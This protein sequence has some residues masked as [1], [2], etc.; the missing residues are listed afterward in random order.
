MLSSSLKF[1]HH[2]KIEWHLG[3]AS[4]GWNQASWRWYK[5]FYFTNW[6]LEFWWMWFLLHLDNLYVDLDKFV[7]KMIN[8]FFCPPSVLIFWYFSFHA[9]HLCWS[10]YGCTELI[11]LIDNIFFSL[12]RLYSE[13]QS[14]QMFLVWRILKTILSTSRTME[15]PYPWWFLII[16]DQMW[17]AVDTGN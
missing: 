14:S 7:I 17:S 1:S 5:V 4:M 3:R 16:S 13:L 8:I 15:D 12:L 9:L 11:Q 2:D 10:S 6:D